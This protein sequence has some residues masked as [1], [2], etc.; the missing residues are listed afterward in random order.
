MYPSKEANVLR[1]HQGTVPAVR[2]N[3]DGQY[4]LS[5]G[6][7]KTVRLWN[8]FKGT[9]IKTYAG[10][11]WEVLDID[12]TNDNSRI[13]SCGGD[14]LAFIWDVASGRVIRRLRGHTQ[15]VNCLS[16]NE[17]PSV[18]VT[19]SY[20]KT[21]RIWDL[22]SNS[23]EPIQTLDEAKDSV[24]ALVVTNY[25]IITASI[26]GKVRNY[27]IRMGQLKT[28]SMGCPV[29]CVT[30]SND[31][32]CILASCLNSRLRLIDKNEGDLLNE[33]IG[34]TNQ[35]YKVESC[36]STDDAYVLS[37]SE[38]GLLY[39]WDLVDAK[40]LH[41]TKAHTRAVCALAYHPN[42]PYLLTSSVDGT[43]KLWK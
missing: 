3:H 24:S 5:G 6:G 33:Y 9:L 16:F 1:G 27:D 43:I 11:G 29:T 37:G 10:H 25:E 14:R 31:Q 20:D 34:H 2:W 19:G 32:N 8:P 26:D 42:Q 39:I 21:V 12:V 30:L 18:V 36:L 22:K 28:D 40:V 7:D 23:S 35:N 41:K 15:R 17:E 38:D 4:C 13:A